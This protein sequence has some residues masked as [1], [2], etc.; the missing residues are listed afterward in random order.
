MLLGEFQLGCY[1]LNSLLHLQSVLVCGS[2]CFYSYWS[3]GVRVIDY[4]LEILDRLTINLEGQIFST[5]T[6]YIMSYCDRVLCLDVE[7]TQAD[8]LKGF[9]HV[10]LLV[11][12]ER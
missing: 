6:R 10:Y 2:L 1:P 3:N 9:L 8:P 12:A 11:V 5:Q 4:G 7:A